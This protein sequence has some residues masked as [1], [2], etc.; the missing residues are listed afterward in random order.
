MKLS[1]ISVIECVCVSI[2]VCVCV[3]PCV[4]PNRELWPDSSSLEPDFL[5]IS[6]SLYVA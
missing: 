5:D 1:A 3:C 2:L 4:C 6:I